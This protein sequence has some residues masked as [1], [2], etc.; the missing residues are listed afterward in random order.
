MFVGL[1]VMLV[2]SLIKK[3]IR[4]FLVSIDYHEYFEI[5]SIIL[6]FFISSTY[7]LCYIIFSKNV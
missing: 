1:I 2:E 7:F 3:N 4:V 6:F 5:V